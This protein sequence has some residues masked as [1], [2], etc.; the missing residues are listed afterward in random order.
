MKYFFVLAATCSLLSTGGAALA[1]GGT[2]T[3][4]VLSPSQDSTAGPGTF[5]V[6]ATG[7]FTFSVTGGAPNGLAGVGFEGLIKVDGVSWNSVSSTGVGGRDIVHLNV[8]GEW[9]KPN[10]TPGTPP[11][12]VSDT[13]SLVNA[14]HAF[15]AS[16]SLSWSVTVNGATSTGSTSDSVTKDFKTGPLSTGGVVSPPPT[17]P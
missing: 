13:R 8:N 12:T 11:C 6:T 7:G 14:T 4:R 1:Q 10:K 15:V 3:A 2:T 16:S 17:F 9:N 5:N